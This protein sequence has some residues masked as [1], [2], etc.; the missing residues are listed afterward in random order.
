MDKRVKDYMYQFDWYEMNKPYQKHVV[1]EAFPEF[2]EIKVRKHESLQ[3]AAG[4]PEIF[5][6]LLDNRDINPY[7][8]ERIMDLVRDWQNVGP[9]L[10]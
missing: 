3:L 1:V 4:V 6:S 10:F 5:E 7:N 2:K 8:R 9:T